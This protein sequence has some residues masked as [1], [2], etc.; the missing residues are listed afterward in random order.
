MPL[1]NRCSPSIP[2]I[3]PNPLT[4]T[5][6]LQDAHSTTNRTKN[7]QQLFLLSQSHHQRLDPVWGL[8]RSDPF[9]FGKAKPE[10]RTKSQ[11]STELSPLINASNQAIWQTKVAP[12]LQGRVFATRRLI[13]QVSSPPAMIVAGL[14][15][16][17]V[18]EPDAKTGG[19]LTPV[20]GCLVG[21]GPGSG[22][23]LIFI[24][25]GLLSTAFSLVYMI[26]TI[27]DVETIMPDHDAPKPETH[28]MAK[29]YPTNNRMTLPTV[30][31][32]DLIDRG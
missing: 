29:F 14:L 23:A 11:S 16:D 30:Y 31:N 32:Y 28:T 10:E 17:A 5:P 25:V 13:A 20:F 21:N 1:N 12:D 15:A 3:M 27:R 22:M 26:P 4:I 24:F 7:L 19:S 18:F 8:I 9:L 6:N 2:N